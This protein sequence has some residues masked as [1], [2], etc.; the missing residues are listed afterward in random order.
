[1]AKRLL[2]ALVLLILFA[3]VG[4]RGVQAQPAAASLSPVART[5]LKYALTAADLPSGSRLAGPP[6]ETVNED[7]AASDPDQAALIQRHGR[8]T[9]I[10]QVATRG[11]LPGSIGASVILFRDAEGAWGDAL[12]STFPAGVQ[13][14]R[15]V[16]GPAVGQRSVLFHYERAGTQTTNGQSRSVRL[17][18]Y[19]I[20]FQ[21][22]RLELAVTIQGLADDVSVD[23]ILPLA[24][25]IDAKVRAAPPGPV[26]AAE[27]ALVEEPTATVLVR[28]A[29]RILTNRFFKPITAAEVLND[30]WT[31]AVQT[32]RRAGFTGLAPL[33]PAYP[34]DDDEQAIA[35]HM[36]SFPELERLGRG[37]LRPEQL[38]ASTLSYIAA[39]R[40]DCHTGYVSAAAW[41]R[42]KA[43]L[44]GESFVA[45]GISFAQDE[46][47]R[48][49][50][51]LPGSPAKAAGLRAGQTITA[52]N[53]RPIAGLSVAE[54]RALLDPTEG[55]VTTFSVLYPSGRSEEI[56]VAPAR[57]S[58]PTLESEILPGNIGVMRFYTFPFGDELL[59]QI[60]QVLTSW[61]AQG[62]QGWIIDVR[63][64]G[65][66]QEPV[67]LDSLFT[68]SGRLYGNVPR[69]GNPNYRVAS[70]RTLPFQRPLVF[71]VGPGSAS[72]AEIFPGS[73]QARGRAVLVGEKTAGCVGSTQFP[74]LLDG[75]VFQVTVTEVTIGPENQRLNGIGVSP[76]VEVAAPTADEDAA[77]IDRQQ[78]AAIDVLRALISDPNAPVPAPSPP[79]AS[80]AVWS[81]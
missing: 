49:V 17:G 26:T 41:Q 46:P 48:L 32:L 74:G 64:N 68:A 29:A 38:A 72:S 35:Y 65:G 6:E 13:V 56:A 63:E 43:Q 55:V 9:E 22:D 66:G 59:N 10:D 3:G 50:S 67:D 23:E 11:D 44:T 34:V 73:L 54:A 20:V 42:T 77:G 70:G 4:T 57:F 31:G 27:L 52:I 24:Q 81:I 40:D 37:L 75:S 36:Q 51:V 28:G 14:D 71:L 16:P 62:V 53:G 19:Q 76:N 2:P 8:F 47:L 25:V 7:V 30:A 78:D 5:L 15:T 1:M 33:V 12:D 80:G 58:L 18:V 61:E 21:R 39:Q 79:V 60:R 45:F 69:Q